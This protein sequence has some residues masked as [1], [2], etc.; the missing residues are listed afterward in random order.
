M[1]TTGIFLRGFFCVIL[2]VI[3]LYATAQTITIPSSVIGTS[4][5][6]PVTY[7]NAPGTPGEW[8]SFHQFMANN[9]TWVTYQYLNSQT[10]GTLS[11]AAPEANGMYDFRMFDP[12]GN[13][14]CRSEPVI[15]RKSLMPDKTFN[16]SG[17]CHADLSGNY[18]DDWAVSV[19]V[20]SNQKI[21]VAGA[22]YS[23]DTSTRQTPIVNF[24]VARF[25][26]D[27]QPDP[28]FGINGRVSTSVPGIEA[29]EVTAMVVQP[30][31]KIIVGGSGVIYGIGL[32]LWQESF[33]LLRYDINGNL[34]PGFGNNGVIITNFTWPT[35]PAG[36]SS[37][38]LTSI[39]LQPDG[40]IIAGG[41]GTQCS[42]EGL[43][44]CN[45][46]RYLPNG[47]IDPGFGIGGKHTFHPSG[48]NE[49][50]TSIAPP[51]VNGDGSFFVAVNKSVWLLFGANENC[52]YKFDSACDPVT[53]FGTDGIVVDPLPALNNSQYPHSIG[54][55]PDSQLYIMGCTGSPGWLW[56]MKRDPISGLSN[57][58]FGT[59]GLV[60]YENPQACIPAGMAFFNNKLVIGHHTPDGNWSSSRFLLNG[61]FDIE[62]GWPSFFMHGSDDQINSMAM[63][64]DGKIILAG[65][66]L[67]SPDLQRDMILVRF[68]TN[69]TKFIHDQTITSGTSDCFDSNESLYLYDLELEN[70]AS[71]NFMATKNV[72]LYAGTIV[73][74]GGYLHA[75]ITTNGNFCGTKSVFVGEDY[76]PKNGHDVAPLIETNSLC[77]LYPNPTNGKL[78]IEILENEE[79]EITFLELYG[80]MGNKLISK[81]MGVQK[82]GVLDLTKFSTGI[83]FIRLIRGTSTTT[84]KIIKN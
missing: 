42:I 20:E 13:L 3:E 2:L 44:R 59:N 27:G 73:R 70:G 84:V 50:V 80:A 58:G 51:V 82:Y 7:N 12:G 40:K 66:G 47:T 31:G 45:L 1:T 64:P 62:F 72:L 67:Y 26:P 71:A 22:A 46:V 49:W 41:F 56:I 77:K 63:Q 39:A 74:P 4:S 78:I 6:I 21:V 35:E 75:G 17:I 15:L 55:G 8:V 54:I 65:S 18:S 9:S 52:I 76:Y 34:D 37:D 29:E 33:I 28:T 10:N 38:R 5:F 16:G 43:R 60:V 61:E 11:F 53:S 57:P 30:D 69:S 83:Y 36:T 48:I 19:K 24:V 79:R 32:C 23:G 81:D 25:N 68:D 14:I